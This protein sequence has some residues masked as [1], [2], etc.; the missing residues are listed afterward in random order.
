[1]AAGHRRPPRSSR[2]A[3]RRRA[4]AAG[5]ARACAGSAGVPTVSRSGVVG[6]VGH[7]CG[8]SPGRGVAHSRSA[9]LST[10]ACANRMQLCLLA[11]AAA[12]AHLD[13][14][15]VRREAGLA[16]P[17]RGRRPTE[18]VVVEMRGLAAIVADQEDAV[19]QAVGM[20]VG[21]IGVGALDP[22]GEVG[23]DEQVEDPVDAVGR[24]PP[25]LVLRD[26]LGDV[27][28]RGRPVEAGQ[29]VEHGGAHRRPLLARLLHRRLRG[30]GEV[31]AF[32]GC[33]GRGGHGLKCRPSRAAEQAAAPRQRLR[34][35][36]GG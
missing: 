30:L 6:A 36:R 31:G 19:V 10:G 3:A 11:I 9:A 22:A 1:M 15:P 23:A 32:D 28:G 16:A 34:S 13:H 14:R 17:P 4:G 29:R 25:A 18:L 21:D 33:D 27:V 8:Y 26:L 7:G 12:A 5:R 24:D 2:R 35:P 20:V